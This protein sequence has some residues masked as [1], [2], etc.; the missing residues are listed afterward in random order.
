MI[1]IQFKHGF[2]ENYTFSV[3]D[4]NKPRKRIM[5]NVFKIKLR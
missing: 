1:K 5:Y 4:L 3:Q 2:I